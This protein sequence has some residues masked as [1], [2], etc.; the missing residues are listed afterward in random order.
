MKVKAGRQPHIIIF[1]AREKTEGAYTAAT[2]MHGNTPAL[3][4]FS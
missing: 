1:R 3:V 4:N 2:C